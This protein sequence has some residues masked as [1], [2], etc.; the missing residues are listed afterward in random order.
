MIAFDRLT[1]SVPTF[2]LRI[3]GFDI[4][5]ADSLFQ[6]GPD[7]SIYPEVIIQVIP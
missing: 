2:V 3:I 5:Y 6:Q 4:R 7:I 1:Q